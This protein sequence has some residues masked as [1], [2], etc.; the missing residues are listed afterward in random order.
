[1]KALSYRNAGLLT[2]SLLL[3]GV[4]TLAPAYVQAAGADTCSFGGDTKFPVCSSFTFDP[5]GDKTLKLVTLPTIGDGTIQFTQATPGIWVVDVDFVSDLVA[6]TGPAGVFEYDLTIFPAPGNNN[7]FLEAGL[8]I[9]GPPVG[10]P[11]FEV[12]KTASGLPK[13]LL[14]DQDNSKDKGLFNDFVKTTRVKDV[15]S[16][17]MGSI[18]SFQNSYRQQELTPKEDVPGPLPLLGAGAAFG[19]SRR[20]RSRVLAAR[21]A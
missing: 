8:A 2:T 5:Q 9:I 12:S 10:D 15:Y 1:M 17:E 14:A 21:R 7:Y 16:I 4:S 3:T 13:T 19:F 6:F 18:N 11:I 20:L